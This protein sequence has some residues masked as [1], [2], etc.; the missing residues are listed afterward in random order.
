MM[1]KGRSIE[2]AEKLK[3]KKLPQFPCLDLSVCLVAR[4]DNAVLC[5]VAGR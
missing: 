5:W 2:I 3:R 4:G 1:M